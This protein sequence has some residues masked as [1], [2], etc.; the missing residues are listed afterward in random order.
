MP[1]SNT[2]GPNGEAEFCTFINPVHNPKR[3]KNICR[4]TEMVPTYNAV[5]NKK[6]TDELQFKSTNITENRQYLVHKD[7]VN[8]NIQFKEQEI[9]TIDS[10]QSK[11]AHIQKIFDKQKID[12][13]ESDSNSAISSFESLSSVDEETMKGCFGKLNLVQ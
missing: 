1:D 13:T 11:I 3:I 2:Y 10:N 6:T 9:I 7:S 8:T 5:Y 4:Y 12:D